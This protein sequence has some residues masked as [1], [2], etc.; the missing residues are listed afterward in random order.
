MHLDKLNGSPFF[1]SSSRKFISLCSYHKA[2]HTELPHS[3]LRQ[4]LLNIMMH[5]LVKKS[6]RKKPFSKADILRQTESLLNTLSALCKIFWFMVIKGRD[7]AA[8]A[9][10]DAVKYQ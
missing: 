7:K 1:F 2:L 9:Q 10:K 3:L 5:L 6:P 4:L 8:V